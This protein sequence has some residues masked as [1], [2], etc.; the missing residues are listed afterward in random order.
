VLANPA[1]LLD[2]VFLCDLD[3]RF[4]RAEADIGRGDIAEQGQR[5][6]S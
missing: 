4:E 3:L 5:A 6:S 2:D 1:A